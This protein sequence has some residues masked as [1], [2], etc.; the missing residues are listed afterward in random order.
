MGLKTI[1]LFTHKTD[2]LIVGCRVT[3]ECEIVDCH[4]FEEQ[5]RI[6][7]TIK[8]AATVIERA[9]EMLTGGNPEFY[10]KVK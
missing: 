9:M 5:Q 7:Y 6:A 1:N 8:Q 10:R 2:I 3:L 4:S